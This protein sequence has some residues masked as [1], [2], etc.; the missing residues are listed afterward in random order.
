[1]KYNRICLMLPTYGR[2]RTM[3]P[4]FLNSAINNIHKPE[5]V[6]FQFVVNK[7]DYDTIATIGEVLVGSSIEIDFNIMSE[8][9]P[10]PNLSVYF[11]MAYTSGK[12]RDVGTVASMVGDDMEFITA[13]WDS[14]ILDAINQKDGQGIFYCSGD[15]R[16]IDGLCVNA[17]ITRQFVE[18][19]RCKFMC[20]QFPANGIDKVWQIVADSMGC[21]YYIDDV[22]ILHHQCSRPGN[23]FDETY[24]RLAPMRK[25][26]IKNSHREKQAANR[27]IKNLVGSGMSL[28]N[29]PVEHIQHGLI[30]RQWFSSGMYKEIINR[31][32][33]PKVIHVALRS[34][35]TNCTEHVI[36]RK[37]WA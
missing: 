8:N 32:E 19:C 15:E 3:L 11:N 23:K 13:D 2:A 22:T 4:R 12:F 9:L 1:M 31:R 17:F 7:S 14:I 30:G 21:G 34:F 18:R 16:F 26:A 20:D 27:I 29:P 35:D 24:E 28:V 6:C 25:L 36:I 37:V 5:Q 33:E 10:K